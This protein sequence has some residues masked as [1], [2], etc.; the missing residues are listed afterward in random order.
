MTEEGRTTGRKEGKEGLALEGRK[1]V[2]KEQIYTE[3]VVPRQAGHSIFRGGSSSKSKKGFACSTEVWEDTM[4][5][6]VH[7][8]DMACD[9]V[10]IVRET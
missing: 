4:T 9:I 1:E 6:V 3:A 2:G 8:S 7:G 10:T 5:E